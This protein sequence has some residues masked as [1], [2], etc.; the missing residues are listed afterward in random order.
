[1]LLLDFVNVMWTVNRRIPLLGS[2]GVDEGGKAA[3]VDYRLF[4]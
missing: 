2:S 3:W 1:M 4:R